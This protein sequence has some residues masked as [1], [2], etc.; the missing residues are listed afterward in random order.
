MSVNP[1]NQEKRMP[2]FKKVSNSQITAKLSIN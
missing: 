1:D 2:A